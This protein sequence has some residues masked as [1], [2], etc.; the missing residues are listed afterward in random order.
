M[1]FYQ[2][3]S[4]PPLDGSKNLPI[5]LQANAKTIATIIGLEITGIAFG[6]ICLAFILFLTFL[7]IFV[8]ASILPLASLSTYTSQAT[9]LSCKL[10]VW[11]PLVGLALQVGSMSVKNLRLFIIFGFLNPKKW[12]VR[13]LIYLASLMAFV[14]MEIALLLVWTYITVPKASSLVIN[15][16]NDF[17]VVCSSDNP[18]DWPNYLLWIYNA[19]LLLLQIL[20]GYLTMNVGPEYNESTLLI[21]S[22][23]LIGLL[24]AI[25]S[26][27]SHTSDIQ[28]L[29]LLR[30]LLV[31]LLE[32]ALLTMFILPKVLAS[33]SDIRAIILKSSIKSL[34][35]KRRKESLEKQ[36]DL[37]SYPQLDTI[38]A[39]PASDVTTLKRSDQMKSSTVSR[40]IRISTVSSKLAYE[41]KSDVPL[42]SCEVVYSSTGLFQNWTNGVI[43]IVR[44]REKV[45]IVFT[46]LCE[47]ASHAIPI[48]ES[49][50]VYETKLECGECKVVRITIT[51]NLKRYP[52]RYIDFYNGEQA[53]A[54]LRLLHE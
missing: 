38:S 3:T 7:S 43:Y 23:V 24:S 27:D 51:C 26:S 25:I 4:Q 21:L 35:L 5:E 19:V 37:K 29:F 50:V 44:C 53:A 54:F 13:D 6:I 45:I 16:N 8:L 33:T 30:P 9:D 34:S 22:S 12:L 28:Q 41:R 40:S 1:I 32:M 2:G 39:L 14:G 15:S 20:A 42:Y 46:S 36:T 52:S 18:H 47:E 31:S 11:L 49:T 17:V 48:L 10:T